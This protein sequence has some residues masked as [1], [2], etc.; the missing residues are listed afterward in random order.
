MKLV[1]VSYARTQGFTDPHRWLKKI[2]F[3]TGIA[4]CQAKSHAV[5]SIHCIQHDGQLLH[6][7]ATYRFFNLNWLQRTF[8]FRVNRFVKQIK[9]AV[10]IMHGLGF[11][12]QLLL[13]KC[14][15]PSQT[16]I[17]VQHHAEKPVRIHKWIFQH[18]ADRLTHGYFFCS[19]EFARQWVRKGQISDLKKVHEVME[20]SSVF[21][22]TDQ[23]KA[24]EVVNIAGSPIYLWV[25][26]LDLNKDPQTL[27]EAFRLF[28]EVRPAAKLYMVFQNDSLLQKV[29]YLV[30]GWTDKIILVGQVDHH[31]LVHWYNASDFIIS[32]SHYEGSGISVCEAMSCGCIPLV[33]RIPSFR[34]M[35]ANGAVGLMFPPGNVKG[36]RDAL[37]ASLDIDVNAQR[38]KVWQQF[39]QQLSFEAIAQKIDQV[40]T[41]VD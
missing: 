37:I 8:P 34:M 14:F 10:V 23:A 13:L 38:S 15:L 33:T 16:K 5:T 29:Q 36:L 40:I 21:S 30:S 31:D 7:G 27:V 28:L 41:A 20:V 3:F 19:R 2:D 35:T 11:G 26:R 9:P 6:E 25:G 4:S 22:R 39:H 1:H 24:R 32:T 12:W 18:I 17:L